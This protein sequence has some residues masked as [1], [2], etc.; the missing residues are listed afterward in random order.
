MSEAEPFRILVG[1]DFSE[2]GDL[3]IKEALHIARGRPAV[4]VHA[5]HVITDV[6]LA[7]TE[8]RNLMEQRDEALATLPDKVW[9]HV[10]SIGAALTPPLPELPVSVHVWLGEAAP[11][12]LKAAATFDVDLLVVGTHGRR[13]L[14]KWLLGSTAQALLAEARCPLLVVRPKDFTGISKEERPVAPLPDDAQPRT[15]R[16]THVYSTRRSLTWTHAPFETSRR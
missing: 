15:W 14:Q 2:V 12:V 7:E 4:E 6:D 5:V 3:A 16:E 13:G 9:T 8:G 1:V 10:Q 11:T